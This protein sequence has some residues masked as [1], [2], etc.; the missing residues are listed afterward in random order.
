MLLMNELESWLD[1]DGFEGL[2]QVSNLGRVRSLDR[3]MYVSQRRYKEPRWT[4]RKGKI[5][6]TYLDGKGYP[7]VRLCKNG[8]AS[9][10]NIHRLV[11]IA[12]I[13]NPDSKPAVNHIDSNPLNNQV[14][15]LEWCTI[16]ENNAH[17]VR[18]GRLNYQSISAKLSPEKVS[19]IKSLLKKGIHPK[20]IALQFSVSRTTII[21][22][23][24]G[25]TWINI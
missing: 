22:I 14:T 9:T 3:G 7:M 24:D 10:I 17:A 16:Q 15:N 19:A 21:G 23:R 2:Y 5:L 1:I 8:K 18:S 6:N 11:C 20:T 13:P 25:K 4:N 12:F